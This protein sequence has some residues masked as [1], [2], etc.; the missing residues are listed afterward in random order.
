MAMRERRVLAGGE[1]LLLIEGRLDVLPA[2][3]IAAVRRA[4]DDDAVNLLTIDLAEV[5]SISTEAVAFLLGLRDRCRTAGKDLRIA[6]PQDAVRDK[7][8]TLGV[9]PILTGRS[10]EAD[11]QGQDQAGA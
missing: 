8:V 2:D 10:E 1:L 11:P 3:V 9:L 7:L 5:R 6:G 4:I